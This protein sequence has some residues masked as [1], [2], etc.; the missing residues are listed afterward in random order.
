MQD[1]NLLANPVTPR[2]NISPTPHHILNSFEAK[3]SG[4][5]FC[6]N[7]ITQLWHS[8]PVTLK[9]HLAALPPAPKC[10]KTT[11]GPPPPQVSVL[12]SLLSLEAILWMGGSEDAHCYSVVN[13]ERVRFLYSR[14]FFFFFFVILATKLYWFLNLKKKIEIHNYKYWFLKTAWETMSKS[15]KWSLCVK[16]SLKIYNFWIFSMMSEKQWTCLLGSAEKHTD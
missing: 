16:G 12:F 9:F 3:L 1:P 2:E 5:N 8:F 7:L 10:I 4:H 15:F 14:C 11:Q 6:L 13:L